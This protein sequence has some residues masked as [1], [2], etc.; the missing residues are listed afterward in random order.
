M[1]ITA[2][3]SLS[4]SSLSPLEL[5]STI[6]RSQFTLICDD[7]DDDDDDYNNDCDHEDEFVGYTRVFLMTMTLTMPLTTNFVG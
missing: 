4:L 5:P 7:D 6:H 3:T 1:M 2:S